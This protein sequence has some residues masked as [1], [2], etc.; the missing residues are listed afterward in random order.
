MSKENIQK[1][2]KT[3]CLCLLQIFFSEYFAVTFLKNYFETHSS[4]KVMG[5]QP[6]ETKVNI[7][8]LPVVWREAWP[9]K[10]SGESS[11]RGGVRPCG[12]VFASLSLHPQVQRAKKGCSR[13]GTAVH[14]ESSAEAGV[15]IQTAS[16]GQ[17]QQG[18][19]L[20]G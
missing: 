13:S 18:Q 7:L 20:T 2:E 16:E 14:L 5:S 11:D 3:T 4:W 9:W 8:N 15:S 1:V 10:D 19:D 12:R 6:K 17:D